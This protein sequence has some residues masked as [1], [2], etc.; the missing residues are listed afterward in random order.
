MEEYTNYNKKHLNQKIIDKTKLQVYEI[1]K[2][3]RQNFQIIIFIYFLV[4][5]AHNMK[6]LDKVYKRTLNWVKKRCIGFF[7]LFT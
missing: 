6:K 4:R 5:F 2:N 1:P 3:C 7:L